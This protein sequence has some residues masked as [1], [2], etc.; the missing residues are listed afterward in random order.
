[1]IYI[2]NKSRPNTPS[3][4]TPYNNSSG[5]KIAPLTQTLWL[6]PVKYDENYWVADLLKLK[7]TVSL[8]KRI[9]WSKVSKVFL[10][11]K[12]TSPVL[13]L[14]KAQNKKSFGITKN[15]R[16]SKLVRGKSRRKSWNYR[17]IEVKRVRVLRSASRNLRNERLGTILLTTVEFRK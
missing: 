17:A 13:E 5:C 6:R 4:G 1:M 16:L 8:T 10:R 3:W 15:W 9:S 11:S 12:N 7:D 14:N 2:T